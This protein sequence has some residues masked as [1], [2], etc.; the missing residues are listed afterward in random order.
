MAIVLIIDDDQC[1]RSGLNDKLR[2]L[3]HEILLAQTGHAGLLLARQFNPQLVLLELTL[4]DISGNDV[5]RLLKAQAETRHIAIV[6]MSERGDEVD[7]IV[8]FELGADDYVVKPFS[9][10]ELALRV[11]AILRRTGSKSRRTQEKCLC[12]TKMEFGGLRVDRDAQKVWANGSKVELT[13]LEFKLLVSLIERRD[14]VQTRTEL[15][16]ETWGV[17]S[18]VSSRTIDSHVKRLRAKL[19]CAG[20]CI[21]TVRGV[22]YRFVATGGLTPERNES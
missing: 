22:G 1:L 12:N 18:S 16:S 8:G 20:V 9:I 4:S 10:R 5:V 2:E 11:Q 21:E 15:L 7:R 13:R 14:R 17:C 19:E 6:I 3:G